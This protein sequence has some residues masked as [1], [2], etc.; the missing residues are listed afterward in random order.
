MEKHGEDCK[1]QAQGMQTQS[2]FAPGQQAPYEV[3]AID[4][5]ACIM[6]QEHLGIMN[7]R[8]SLNTTYR[9]VLSFKKLFAPP[10]VSSDFVLECR[11]FGEKVRT[12][13]YTWYPFEIRRRGE[14]RGLE[15]ASVL[16]LPPS[17]RVGIMAITLNTDL[18][19]FPLKR[20]NRTG[21]GTERV[22]ID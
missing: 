18:I 17:I 12:R 5:E 11:L 10:Y 1:Q 3:F 7:G 15:V 22:R 21:M 9:D 19:P 14:L 8:L 16:L 4:G 13:H 20:Q 2:D 6:E